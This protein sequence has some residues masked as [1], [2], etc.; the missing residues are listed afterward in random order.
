MYLAMAGPVSSRSI[1]SLLW[2]SSEIVMDLVLLLICLADA[3]G[4]KFIEKGQIH[5][6]SGVGVLDAEGLSCAGGL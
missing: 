4:C 1:K 5:P 2:L 6:C 3:K